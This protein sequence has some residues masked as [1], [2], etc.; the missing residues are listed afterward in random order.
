MGNQEL[1]KQSD[2]VTH[3]IERLFTGDINGEARTVMYESATKSLKLSDSI[4]ESK[5]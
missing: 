1:S 5:S 3:H 2:E 4:Q